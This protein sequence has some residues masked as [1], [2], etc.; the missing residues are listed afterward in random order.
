MRLNFVYFIMEDAGSAQDLRNY[1]LAARELGHEVRLYGPP[2]PESPFNFS[3]DVASADAVVFIFEWTTDLRYGD[4]LDL[5]RLIGRVPRER[6][7]VIDCDGAYNDQLEVEGDYN[8]RDAASSLAWRRI[9]ESLSD[10][11]CQPTLHPR[12]KDVR[13]FFFHAYDPSWER[14]LGVDGKEYGMAYVGHSKFRWPPMHRVLKAVEPVRDRVGRMVVVG[15]GWDEMPE[16]AGPMRM[17]DAYFTDKEYMR[18]MGVEVVQPVPS[19]QVIDWMSRA[20]FNPVIYRPLFEE[21]RLVTCRTFETPG[22]ATIPLFGLE[23][24]YV[25]EI[26]GEPA[27][28]LRLPEEGPE[29]K[30]EDFFERPGH[31]RNVVEE[32]RDHLRRRHSYK[33]R[34]RELID[35]VME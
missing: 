1:V 14:S 10:K 33:A 19:D 31:Y 30:I 13:T 5:T 25:E 3:M 4:T 12:K 34:I 29:A 26:Y 20:V 32:I 17:E 21:L 6:R 28:E 18:R 22:A 27:Q 2:S 8:H 24:A 16:W 35:I 7:V 11:I 15:H 9:C 23:S